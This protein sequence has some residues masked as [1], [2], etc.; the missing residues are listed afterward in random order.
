MSG[1]P[2]TGA[3]LAVTIAGTSYFLDTWQIAAFGLTLVAAGVLLIR[4]GW[5]RNKPVNQA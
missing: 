4:F 5:R 1:L 3:G 2:K